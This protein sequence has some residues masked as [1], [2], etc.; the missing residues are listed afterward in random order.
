[1]VAISSF[2]RHSSRAPRRFRR[3][4]LPLAL[5]AAL[6][7][8]TA[9]AA[10][11]QVVATQL[12]TGGSIAGG[13][14]TINPANGSSL[15]VGQTSSRMVLTWSSFDI[16]SAAT[17]LFNQPGSSA[18][19]LNL[20]Q[21]GNPTQ[22][23]GSLNANGQV[24]LLNRNGL[25]V[26]DTAQIN[27]G[28]LVLTTLGTSAADFMSG[29]YAFD[30]G[31]NTVALVSNSGT[32]NATAGG[33][34]LIGGRVSNSG[35]ITAT[36]GNITLA[37]A[38]AA[39]LTFESG[40]F[41]VVINKS[42]QLALGPE[43]IDNSG[44]LVTTGGAISLQ[45]SAAQ[46][47]FDRLINHTG[48][49]R[50]TSLSNGADGSVSLTA[51]GGSS[52]DIV[53]NGS[54]DVGT[55]A[56][57][58]SAGRSVQQTGVLTA[59]SLGGFTG[60]NATFSG[61]N[62][63]SRLGSFDVS[64]NFSLTNTV[65]LT[66][67]G[68]L[69]IGGSAAFSQAGRSI[70]LDNAGNSFG[71]LVSATGSG[72]A[73]S[74]AGTLSIGTLNLGSNTAL[75]L[76]AGG[77]LNLPASAIDTGSANLSLS[78]GGSLVT[79]AALAGGNVRIGAGGA[80][81][82][83]HDIEANGALA[84]AADA[85]ITQ[86]GGQVVALGTS[87]VEAGS[88]ISLD[89]A[90]NDFVGQ[91]SL[92]GSRISVTDASDLR[93]AA[94]D[95][96]GTGD[97]T[98]R[99][100][101]SLILPTGGLTSAGNLTL[102]AENGSLSL[103]GAL[104][105]ANVSL[106]GGNG[107]TL[108]SNIT[109]G[110]LSLGTRNGAINQVAGVIDVAGATTI[111][112][113]TGA[114]SL[115]GAGN[116]FRGTVGIT[117]GSARI[118]DRDALALGA[119]GVLG[120]LRATSGGDL[121]L[122]GQVRAADVDLVVG[123]LFQ[124]DVGANALAASG[125]W[126]VFLP[127]PLA[128]HAYNGLDSGA[129]AVW[130]TRPSGPVSVG[131]N[132][133][134]FAYQPTLRWTSID[135]SK[136]YGDAIGLADA[137]T[138]SGLMPGVSGAYR[139]DSLDAVVTGAPALDSLGRAVTATVAGGPYAIEIGRGTLD[140]ATSGYAMAFDSAGLL[141]VNRAGLT[142][143]AA[144]ASKTYGQAVV[145]SAYSVSGLRNSDTVSSVGLASAGA[146]ASAQVGEYVIT[147]GG[148]DGSG[149]SNYDITY[150]D[151]VLRVGKAGL[152]IHAGNV[153]KTYGDAVSL[154]DFTVEGLRND[155]RVSSAT[156]SSDGV[157]A[158]AAVG[159]YRIA[160]S[161]ADGQGLSNYDITYTDGTLSVG[162][163]GLTITAA[164]AG[165]V[166]GD[167]ATLSGYAVSG[168]RNADAV[169]DVT[170]ESEGS[171][172][173]ASVG[174]YVIRAGGADGSGL[175]NYDITYVDGL[176]SVRKAGLTITALG[177]S[178][179]YGQSLDPSMFQAEG[180]R[181]ADAV[182][183]VLLSSD[184]SAQSAVVGDYLIRAS[185]ASGPGLSNYDITYVDG[186][187]SVGKA[188]L[189]ITALDARKT[190]GDAAQLASYRVD[191]LVNADRVSN[192]SLSSSGEAETA[193]VGNYVIRAGGAVGDGLSNYTIRYVDGILTV[194]KAGL[195]I[196]ASDETKRYGAVARLDGYTASG[197][198]NSDQVSSV[199]LSSAGAPA[200]ALRG[201]Y[202]IEASAASGSGLSN[203]DIRYVDGTLSVIDAVSPADADA[204]ASATRAAH[205]AGIR[206]DVPVEA[207]SAEADIRGGGVALP[208]RCEA[209]DGEG[210]R[211]KPL[212]PPR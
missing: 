7:T 128:P 79:S 212:A 181:N 27:V 206:E 58:I 155:D 207:S 87:A 19:V 135:R 190:Y 132:R 93:I 95:N 2:T 186:V 122:A 76:A 20:V 52:F 154:S 65:D 189:T 111:D 143:Q 169:T 203:Y 47:I 44:T 63:I 126:H 12:P 173:I 108:G 29:N 106:F 82:L 10:L 60:G 159:D 45:A 71:G 152:T 204:I 175:S 148:A 104:A 209:L 1:M 147:A 160:A 78:S 194:D 85:S 165:K 112:A 200:D 28:G 205:A 105:G 130:N 11:A 113:G 30:A 9:P 136:T 92:A 40:G 83:A 176:L 201:R 34:S 141:T 33:V 202:R 157:A 38:D 185:G 62:R 43:A 199:T 80:L 69:A 90:G 150:V 8:G 35:T 124:N 32:I 142:V 17:V 101:G 171:V 6:T 5:A 161:N 149:L 177:A 145:P 166:Y 37:G 179:T 187:L 46:G 158:T 18:A 118:V 188:A 164:N 210:A 98:L 61:A 183:S 144:D 13:T 96:R 211:C 184:G 114:V 14:G 23:Y 21:G 24:F 73:I 153:S 64:G 67:S 167:T 174:G 137:H 151:G 192:V 193:I 26:G 25:L 163:A 139:A 39:T 3:A 121:R 68:A 88:A 42:L 138:V 197:L 168:L 75:S 102:R 16:G 129:A 50:A 123:G 134:V 182:S 41:A 116:D 196:T 94:L 55:G 103:G 49:I 97:I 72:V 125:R 191:G 140:A 57:S 22:I 131:G 31:G 81:T 208:P 99:A 117:A 66:Q 74:A 36:S 133:Y 54:I 86:V 100:G 170:L 146:P 109:G 15:T 110:A 59:G 77:T 48:T 120:A 4:A 195:T 53:G 127:S 198:K 84:L 162:K 89:N 91:V 56:V 172:A 107:L 180:L 115:E 156:L 51:R 119:T 178:K 70:T